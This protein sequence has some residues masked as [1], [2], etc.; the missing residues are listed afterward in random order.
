MVSLFCIISQSNSILIN[1]DKKL[2]PEYLL[3]K[4]IFKIITRIIQYLYVNVNPILNVKYRYTYN[5]IEL[6]Q[7][8]IHN[9]KM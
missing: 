9:Y 6:K 5:M 4:L 2:F 3:D 7:S 1:I 8:Y